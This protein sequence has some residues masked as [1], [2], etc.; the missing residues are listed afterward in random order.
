MRGSTRPKRRKSAHIHPSSARAMLTMFRGD[1]VR[2]RALATGEALV[3]SQKVAK[4][5]R[6]LKWA[7]VRMNAEPKLVSARIT[8]LDAEGRVELA[9]VVVQFDSDQVSCLGRRRRGGWC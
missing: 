3:L 9:Q 2:I 4:A 7:L 6:D 1:E 8:P 5:R